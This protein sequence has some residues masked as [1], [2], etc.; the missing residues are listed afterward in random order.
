MS[1]G[2]NK[3]DYFENSNTIDEFHRNRRE[4]M[5]T[6]K[7]DGSGYYIGEHVHWVFCDNIHESVYIGTSGNGKALVISLEDE[8]H[9]YVCGDFRVSQHEFSVL[10]K[11]DCS[12][13][14]YNC[15]RLSFC[16]KAP[17]TPSH[18]LIM[19]RWWKSACN[20]WGRVERF[21]DA[22]CN[23]KPYCIFGRWVNSS[24]FIGRVDSTLPPVRGDK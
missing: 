11:M 7:P 5:R 16:G 4:F 24:Y 23:P 9:F 13:P 20:E 8:I 3:S 12:N 2:G 18:S 15:G 10:R 14:C 22:P 6:S 19:G 17:D 21:N 1:S